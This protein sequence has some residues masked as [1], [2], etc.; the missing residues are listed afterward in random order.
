M[1]VVSARGEMLVCLV[2]QTNGCGGP[3]FL[4]AYF[5]TQVMC[6]K[7]SDFNCAHEGNEAVVCIQ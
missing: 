2:E 3:V 6:A 4:M 7:I 1:L 5:G